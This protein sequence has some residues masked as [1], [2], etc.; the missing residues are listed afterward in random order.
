MRLS[1]VMFGSLLILSGSVTGTAHQST[2]EAATV[3]AI[4]VSGARPVLRAVEALRER[5]QVAITYEEPRYVYAQDLEDISYIHKGP[6]PSGV[7]LIAPRGG[8][9]HFRYAEMNGKPQEDMA[10]LIQR[11]LM[12]HAAQGGPL[13]DVRERTMPKGIQWNV[14]ALKARGSSGDFVDQPDILGVPIFIPKERR[15]EAEFLKEMLQQLRTETGY[16]V[17]LGTVETRINWGTAELG[18]DNVPARDA[19]VSLFGR[20]MVWDLNYDPEGGGKYVLNLLWTPRPPQPLNP[21]PPPPALT[22]PTG[23]GHIPPGA[24]LH[25]MTTRRGRME[26]QSKLAQAGY[27]TGAPSGEWD[28]ATT[29]GLKKFQ[30]ANNLPVTGRLDFETIHKLG[31]DV[32]QP[33]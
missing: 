2:G 4:D 3:R 21:F 14:V 27:Y 18:A 23:P 32:G 16:P 24:V 10:S 25:Q 11:L 6:V 33:Q 22:R 7:K 12:E 15:T 20:E 9:I 28:G 8:T 26:L 13:F 30:A 31:L 29:E 17:V 1:N 19:L 5:Y